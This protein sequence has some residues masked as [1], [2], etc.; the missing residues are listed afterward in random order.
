[1]PPS[2]IKFQLRQ[3]YNACLTTQLTQHRFFP[4]IR[5]SEEFQ[6]WQ[7][8]CLDPAVPRHDWMR[9]Q[10]DAWLEIM[11]CLLSWSTLQNVQVQIACST[12]INQEHSPRTDRFESD[13][14][15]N[16]WHLKYIPL[17][18]ELLAL[19]AVAGYWMIDVRNLQLN[20]HLHG[21]RVW[22]QSLMFKQR[23]MFYCWLGTPMTTRSK[24]KEETV[25]V[26]EVTSLA[27]LQ[28]GEAS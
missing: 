11:Y 24:C 5:W 14:Y 8:W 1:M 28:N 6:T 17:I 18:Y 15:L 12:F 10:R 9:V 3:W 21:S 22:K 25:S 26:T 4:S 19:W 16:V 27:S 7:H 20:K 23:F 2:T 13:S